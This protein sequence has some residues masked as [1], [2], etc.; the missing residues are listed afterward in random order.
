MKKIVFG[1]LTTAAIA[2]IFTGCGGKK[3]QNASQELSSVEK[4]I[5]EAEKMP[6]EE[7]YKSKNLTAKLCTELEIQ[8]VEKRPE[9]HLLKC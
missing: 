2:C 3:K 9:R 6:L 8:A 7:L 4:V 5:A 1:M